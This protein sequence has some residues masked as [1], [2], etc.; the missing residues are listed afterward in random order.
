[1]TK[2]IT[3]RG[4]TSVVTL[5]ERRAELARRLMQDRIRE[6]ERLAEDF[7]ATRD[8]RELVAP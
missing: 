4:A 3:E 7:E 8:P 6:A 5:A 1:M 2:K